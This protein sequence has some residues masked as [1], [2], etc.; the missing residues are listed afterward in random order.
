MTATERYVSPLLAFWS[1]TVSATER[2]L[3]K[4]EESFTGSS[5]VPAS[6][7]NH[8]PRRGRGCAAWRVWGRRGAQPCGLARK[9]ALPPLTSR[10]CLNAAPK[11]AQRVTRDRP[12]GEHRSAVA[13][14]R[15][16]PPKRQA[17][18][19]LPRRP[20]RSNMQHPS[21]RTNLQPKTH[22]NPYH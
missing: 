16:P 13:A 7:A 19:S 10:V 1:P 18:Q 15:Q 20:L 6:A 4:R 11:G 9:C 22:S 3:P 21:I 12:Q 14:K 5:P 8:P 2:R 17:T